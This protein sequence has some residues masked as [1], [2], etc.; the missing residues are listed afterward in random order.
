MA[1]RP[2]G[3]K[4]FAA[5]LRVAI[6]EAGKEEGTTKLRDIADAL[7]DKAISGDTSAIKEIADRLD[8]KA[9][10]TISGP[11]DGPI[12]IMSFDVEKLS[13]LDEKQLEALESACIAMGF[14][15]SA[16]NEGGN[17]DAGGDTSDQETEGS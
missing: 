15:L 7:V 12:P 1:G 9:K 8:G 5:M 11:N 14:D 13:K 6:N 16:A 2:K 3:P 4:S 17:G 10:Q